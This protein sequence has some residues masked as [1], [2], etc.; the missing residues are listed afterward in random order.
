RDYFLLVEQCSGEAKNIQIAMTQEAFPKYQNMTT[1]LCDE[2]PLKRMASS[3]S[4]VYFYPALKDLGKAVEVVYLDEE[5]E[6]NKT[7]EQGVLRLLLIAVNQEI[8]YCKK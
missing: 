5:D 7:H 4:A 3:D 1:W 6:A 8:H 2:L